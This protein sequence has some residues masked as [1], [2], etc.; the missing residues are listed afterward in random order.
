MILNSTRIDQA[1]TGRTA[2]DSLISL[3]FLDLIINKTPTA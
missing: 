2:K 1:I 3:L